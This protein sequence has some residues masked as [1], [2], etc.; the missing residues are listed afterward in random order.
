MTIEIIPVCINHEIHEKE[1]LAELIISSSKTKIQDGDIIALAT[2]IKGL[3]VTHTGFAIRA[4]ADRVHLLHASS[5][6]E[7]EVSEKPLADYLLGIKSNL[8]IIVAR[9]Q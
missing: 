7:V 8:G 3:D 5:S 9:P 1:K 6:G 2:S 4:N